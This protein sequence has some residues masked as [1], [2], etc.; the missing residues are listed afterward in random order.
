[1]T[2]SC[3]DDGERGDVC[4]NDEEREGRDVDNGLDRG[5]DCV[6]D[7]DRRPTSPST[8]AATTT[9]K[10]RSDNENGNRDMQTTTQQL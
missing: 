8:A 7:T 9:T 6:V 2:N 4:A 1:M 10:T 3:A 5:R